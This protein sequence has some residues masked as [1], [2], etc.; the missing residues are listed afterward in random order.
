VSITR[1]ALV[2]AL[3]IEIGAPASGQFNLFNRKPR[4]DAS[5]VRQ[6]IDI[7]RLDPDEKKRQAAILE[8]GGADPRVQ[9]DVIPVISTALLKDPSATVRLAAAQVIGRFQ[10]VFPM[11]GVA[12]ETAAESDPSHNVREAAQ[13]TLWEY[14][15]IGYRSVRGSDGIVG[16][17]VEPPIAKPGRLSL[18]VTAEPPIRPAVGSRSLTTDALPPVAELP[19]PRVSLVA[20]LPRPL[21]LLSS[22]APHTNL[23]AEPPLAAVPS[24][25]SS[26]MMYPLMTA[27]EP[28]LRPRWTEPAPVGKPHPIAAYL[29]PIVPHPG[30]IPGV[31]PLPTPTSEPPIAR[32][33]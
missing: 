15:L 19:G 20:K 10:I 12:L 22:A 28:P 33:R 30:P 24:Q 8:L 26:K 6:L 4:L 11:A 18:P 17:S 16:Q 5:R 13:Q 21:T 29:P 14:H 2:L 32:D 7:V 3:F 25:S 9:L 23:T 31:T 27:T 1:T